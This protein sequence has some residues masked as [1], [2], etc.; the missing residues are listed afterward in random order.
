MWMVVPYILTNDGKKGAIDEQ[1]LLTA[2][3]HKRLDFV[4]ILISQ[5]EEDLDKLKAKGDWRR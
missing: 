5:E 4:L 2:P 1:Q 3:L